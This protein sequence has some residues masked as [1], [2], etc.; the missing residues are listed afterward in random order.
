MRRRLD[1]LRN[2]QRH[3]SGIEQT[4]N[5]AINLRKTE[6][7]H[8]AAAVAGPT[9]GCF[10]RAG[11]I[12]GLLSRGRTG[13][14]VW[15]HRAVLAVVRRHLD[16]PSPWAFGGT[17]G[18]L[19]LYN[20]GR[21]PSPTTPKHREQGDGKSVMT[22]APAKVPA[23]HAPSTATRPPPDHPN[24]GAAQQATHAATAQPDSASRILA[25]HEPER[26]QPS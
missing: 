5:A 22:T 4:T 11:L 8:A 26:T 13:C 3:H 16:D 17:D 2:D 6:D 25:G 10:R 20:T 19:D 14:L 23:A 15:V 18:A 9:L 21:L 7:G 12:R 1:D 24:S